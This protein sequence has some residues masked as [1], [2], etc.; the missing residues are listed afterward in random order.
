MDLP[1]IKPL[2]PHSEI[3]IEAIV[4][5]GDDLDYEFRRQASFRAWISTVH[6]ESKAKSRLDKAELELLKSRLTNKIRKNT[7]GLTISD[8]EAR[9]IS[10]TK[11][12]IKLEELHNAQKYEDV[13]K[14]FLEAIDTKRD[15]LM[16]L[17]ANSRV[18]MNPEFRLMAKRQK[19]KK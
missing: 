8:V 19:F 10:S 17:G 12:R 2:K 14:G 15:M 9:V 7:K 11:Y 13:L 18:E 16:Q 3:D 6:A 1:S 5:V 4:N